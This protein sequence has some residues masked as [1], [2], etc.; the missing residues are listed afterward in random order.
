MQFKL[1]LA[2]VLSCCV[3]NVHATTLLYK[4]L[5]DLAAESEGIV[6]GTVVK[7]ESTYGFN[8]NIYTFVTLQN[9]ENIKGQIKESDLALRFEGGQVGNEIQDTVGSPRFQ[10]GERVVLFIKGNGHAIVPL[11][12]WTQGVFRVVADPIS[13]K[14]IVMDHEGNKLL[15]VSGKS[16]VKEYRFEPEAHILNQDQRIRIQRSAQPEASLGTTDDGQSSDQSRQNT[17]TEGQPLSLDQFL[18]DIKARVAAAKAGLGNAVESAGLPDTTEQNHQ[19]APM[20]GVQDQGGAQGG[21]SAPALPRHTPVERDP[22]N[23]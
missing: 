23:Q 15:G 19:V 2:L 1:M 14:S 21:S 20:P 3:V 9:I 11:V 8:K 12:G 16:L 22:N 13:G 5:D 7:T 10:T 18:S 17:M 4:N 6:V